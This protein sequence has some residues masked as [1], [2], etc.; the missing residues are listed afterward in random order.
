M[1]DIALDCSLTRLVRSLRRACDKS[2]VDVYMTK[3]SAL[4]RMTYAPVGICLTGMW[5]VAM[6]RS[7]NFVMIVTA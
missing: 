7:D 2:G 6:W 4:Q 1:C 3:V 5:N